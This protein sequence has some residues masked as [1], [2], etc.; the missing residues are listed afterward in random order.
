[1]GVARRAKERKERGDEPHFLGPMT[2]RNNDMKSNQSDKFPLS[3]SLPSLGRLSLP[4]ARSDGAPVFSSQ[5]AL[6]VAKLSLLLLLGETERCRS[7]HPTYLKG[8]DRRR[9]AR[10]RAGAQ[11]GSTAMRTPG[12]PSRAAGAARA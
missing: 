9:P 10:W 7:A 4:G 3:R 11:S 5:W 8:V 6:R 1:M 12:A 2:R